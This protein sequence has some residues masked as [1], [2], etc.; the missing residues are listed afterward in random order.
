MID[1]Y[2]VA[3][4]EKIVKE[5]QGMIEFEKRKQPTTMEDVAVG[6]MMKRF[7]RARAKKSYLPITSQEIELIDLLLNGEQEEADEKLEKLME[8]YNETAL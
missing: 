5:R 7:F 4:K 6:K 3:Q 8:G 1:P 2:I